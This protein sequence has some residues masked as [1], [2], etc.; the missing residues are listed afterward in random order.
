[1][2]KLVLFSILAVIAVACGNSPKEEAQ[3]EKTRDSAMK[4]QQY[5]DSI[6][7]AR[8]E[9]SLDRVAQEK[10]DSSAATEVK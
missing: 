4:S 9:D 6:S 2:K 3:E 5:L 1:M 8:M 7:V 10:L